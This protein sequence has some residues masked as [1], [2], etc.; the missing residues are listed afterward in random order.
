MR[1][2]LPLKPNDTQPVARPGDAVFATHGADD[3]RRRRC[4][5]CRHQIDLAHVAALIEAAALIADFD[6]VG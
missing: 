6:L 3:A 1:I 5:I 2:G 4:P